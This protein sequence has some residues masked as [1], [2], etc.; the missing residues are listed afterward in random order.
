MTKLINSKRLGLIF[1]TAFMVAP[2]LAMAATTS[3]GALVSTS[4]DVRNS[5]WEYF[6]GGTYPNFGSARI[7]ISETGSVDDTGLAVDMTGAASAGPGWLRSSSIARERPVSGVGNGYFEVGSYASWVE[8]DMVIS[9]P[10]IPN[11]Y[12]DSGVAYASV[13]IDGRIA[14]QGGTWQVGLGFIQSGPAYVSFET[15][16]GWSME[17]NFFGNGPGLD[18]SADG[19]VSYSIV[20]PIELHFRFGR[21]FDF[22]LGLI[23]VAGATADGDMYGLSSSTV[24]FGHTLTWGGI[25]KITDADGNEVIGATLA[26]GSSF[27]YFA[28]AIAPAIPEPETYAMMLAG[29]GLI[30]GVALRRKQQQALE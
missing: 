21:E 30:G 12:D 26:A 14:S 6:N 27:D 19:D 11:L 4:S 24:D 8:K 5:N 2:P 1:F 7:S 20:V 29:L 15:P 17:N 22:G 10:S 25:K 23:T 16:V 9:A 18:S 13:A 3:F 28:P